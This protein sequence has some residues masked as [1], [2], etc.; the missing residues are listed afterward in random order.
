MKRD[1]I[2]YKF[3]ARTVRPWYSTEVH[4]VKCTFDDGRQKAYE[5]CTA[6]FADLWSVYLR[7]NDGTLSCIADFDTEE[8][9]KAF[10]LFLRA[11]YGEIKT[12]NPTM[13]SNAMAK[14]FS[15]FDKS[16]SVVE[17]AEELL[18]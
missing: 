8:N 2:K 10:D 4:P 16:K 15:D 5:R 12:I 6:E 11:F 1:T 17:Q 7:L 3:D 18:S 14:Y 13:V 9:A